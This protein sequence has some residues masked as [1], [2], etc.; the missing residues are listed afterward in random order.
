MILAEARG[1]I[2]HEVG[3][4]LA[5]LAA[6]VPADLAIVELGSYKGMSTAHLAT[7]AKDGQGAHVYA[8]DPWDLPGN[9]YGKHGYSAP[10]VREE[11]E[12][13]LRA[14]RL[15]S[16]VT[17]VRAFST[18]AAADW[19]GPPVGLLYVDADH[20]ESA[21]RADVAAWTPHLADGHVLA[22]DDLDT[23]RNPGVRVVVE[24]LVATGY[25]LDVQAE[26]LAVLTC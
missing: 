6:E 20:A 13:Q 5:V 18:D 19:S 12:S 14:L 15:W 2:T 4:A 17:P 21:V 7:G 24:E 9:V 22:F 16:R 3:Q 8:V 1:L 10:I 11:F 25:R 26:R 23:P